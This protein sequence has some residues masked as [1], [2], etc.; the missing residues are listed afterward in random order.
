MVDAADSVNTAEALDNA[1][2]I[3][4]DVVIDQV[5]AVLK[6][7]TLADAVRRDEKVNLAVL[8][9]GRNLRA[10]FCVRGKVCQNLVEGAFTKSGAD[11]A[12]AAHESHVDAEFLVRPVEQRIVEVTCGIGKSGENENFLIWLAE[13]GRCRLFQLRNDKFFQFRQLGI[14]FGRDAAGSI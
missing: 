8:W 7:L 10:F 5:V 3:P 1:H 6:I 11:I 14:V 13:L 2:G 4:V 9:H 12:A